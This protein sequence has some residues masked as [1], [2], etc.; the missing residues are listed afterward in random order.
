[1]TLKKV[2]HCMNGNKGMKILTSQVQVKGAVHI[3]RSIVKNS[4]VT[5]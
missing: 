4:P 3:M 2:G 1:M 5:G